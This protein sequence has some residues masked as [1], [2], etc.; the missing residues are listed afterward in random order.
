MTY[1][2]WFT[3]G[4]VSEWGKAPQLMA[5]CCLL[6][7][8]I[9]GRLGPIIFKQIH[10]ILEDPPKTV[11][12]SECHM[13]WCQLMLVENAWEKEDEKCESLKLDHWFPEM[14]KIEPLWS[15]W[16]NVYHHLHDVGC[17]WSIGGSHSPLFFGAAP[18]HQT[19]RKGRLWA[20]PSGAL[21]FLCQAFPSRGCL[22]NTLFQFR[23]GHMHI[24]CSRQFGGSPRQQFNVVDHHNDLGCWAVRFPTS[25]PTNISPHQLSLI[26]PQ[27]TVPPAWYN[28]T[29]PALAMIP[30]DGCCLGARAALAAFTFGAFGVLGRS[31]SA[32]GAASS[33]VSSAATLEP[34]QRPVPAVGQNWVWIQPSRAT[35]C[36]SANF[37]EMAIL[38]HGNG[39]EFWILTKMLSLDRFA[40]EAPP[41]LEVSDTQVWCS[42]IDDAT[43]SLGAENVES[44]MRM[45][46]RW[47]I[48]KNEDCKWMKVPL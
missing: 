37:W 14:G 46:M 33:D 19:N 11:P 47:I 28:R 38:P 8:E 40:C 34:P 36:R 32:S 3:R 42:Q 29:R 30:L 2:V 27:K 43:R 25:V 13:H 22:Q 1:T 24:H 9:L 18:I 12:N 39:W 17:S 35:R 10:D 44:K 5:K 15:L 48:A 31:S 6:N 45:Q 16:Y 41:S 21:K 4:W 7:G 23:Q 20:R 26:F